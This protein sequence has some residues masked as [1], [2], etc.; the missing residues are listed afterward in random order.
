MKKIFLLLSFLLVLSSCDIEGE[1][2]SV[3]VLPVE[4]VEIPTEFELGETYPITMRYFR[5][6]NC[7]SP[8][9]IY[10]E[11]DLNVRICAI[12]NLKTSGGNCNTLTN[13]LVEETFNFQV[14]NTGNYIFKFWTGKDSE[15]NDTFLEYDIPVN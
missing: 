14:T 8:Y 10:Y 1:S 7:H 2:V 4:S 15:G 6:S 5:P 12:N 9:G 11:K 13:I 3:V